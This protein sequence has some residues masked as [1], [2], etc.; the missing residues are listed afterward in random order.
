M[1]PLLIQKILTTRFDGD[2]V[3]MARTAHFMGLIKSGIDGMATM[4]VVLDIQPRDLEYLQP[5]LASKVDPM[6]SLDAAIA[7]MQRA[8]TH[9]TH[10]EGP[11]DQGR[12]DEGVR[13]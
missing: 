5:V 8:S 9:A 4:G 10:E 6:S 3:K 12:H 2:D 7:H 13:G 1:D 11:Q